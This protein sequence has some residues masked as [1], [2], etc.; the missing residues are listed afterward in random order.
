[1]SDRLT[2]TF[3]EWAEAAQLETL[4]HEVLGRFRVRCNSKRGDVASNSGS[5][6]DSGRAM[7]SEGPSSTSE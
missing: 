4:G 2:R 3:F 7:A 5:R 6:D 1:V